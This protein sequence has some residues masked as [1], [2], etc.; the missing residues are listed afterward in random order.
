MAATE[1]I[2]CPFRHIE[3]RKVPR[4]IPKCKQRDGKHCIGS[5]LRKKELKEFENAA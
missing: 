1:C 3:A 4:V 5:V 2:V